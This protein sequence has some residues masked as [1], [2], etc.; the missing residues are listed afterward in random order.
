MLAPG[1]RALVAVSGGKDSLAVWDI[2]LELG[3]Q[4]DGLYLGLG[5]GDYSDELGRL[6]PR[7]RRPSAASRSSRST[8]PTDHGFDIPTGARAAR[9]R[10][11]LGVRAVQAPPLRP[12]R[13]R[14][15]LRRRRH[16]PQ[17][18]RRGRRAVRQRAALADRLPRPPAP[19]AAG[20]RRLPPQGQ[21]AGA[22]RRARDGRLLRAPR[23]RLHRRGVPDGGRQQAP[24]LQGGAQRHRGDV[25]GHEAR[26]LLRL[27]RP[28]LAPVRRPTPS[29][30]Q[31][32]RCGRARP[33]GAPTTGEVCAF[34]RLVERAAAVHRSS[35]DRRR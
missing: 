1:E 7:L 4:A 14:R 18:R 12:G 2:L 17:P 13:A 35:S 33:C 23:H 21:A 5:I 20:P 24:R 29:A 3:Y 31:R 9:A 6:R 8:C 30:E 16:R 25:A 10:P 26:L 28:G 27:P 34:C 32:R 19:G 22:P 15:R 11:V